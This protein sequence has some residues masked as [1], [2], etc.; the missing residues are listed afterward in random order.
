MKSPRHKLGW[1]Q[2]ESK[3]MTTYSSACA[4]CCRIATAR[5]NSADEAIQ[6]VRATQ[7]LCWHAGEPDQEHDWTWPAPAEREVVPART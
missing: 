2:Q 5:A 1:Q 6:I 3:T 4:R 7:P